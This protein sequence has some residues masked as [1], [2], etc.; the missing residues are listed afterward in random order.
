MKCA[1]TTSACGNNVTG[2]AAGLMK[3]LTTTVN[4]GVRRQVR[5]ALDA[6]GVAVNEPQ[7]NLLVSGGGGG[8]A[9]ELSSMWSGLL[10]F[11]MSVIRI[12]INDG[13]QLLNS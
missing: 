2:F 3:L 6:M 8:V 1:Y 10:N 7:R 12:K 11:G 5:G 13:N 4:D 9:A